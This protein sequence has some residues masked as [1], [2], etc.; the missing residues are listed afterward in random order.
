MIPRFQ[1]LLKRGADEALEFWSVPFFHI[2]GAGMHYPR[3]DQQGNPI[4]PPNM[5]PAVKAFGPIPFY[6]AE[7]P[8]E[9]K[10]VDDLLAA[11]GFDG[12]WFDSNDVEGFLREKG[13]FLDGH[14]SF[15]E[16]SQEHVSSLQSD[17]ERSPTMITSNG[18]QATRGSARISI[19]HDSPAAVAEQQTASTVPR[20]DTGGSIRKSS[21]QR[22]SL[23]MDVARFLEC[24]YADISVTIPQ[25]LLLL[26]LRH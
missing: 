23:V 16:L 22:S 26:E 19:S 21:H 5:H 1:K 6:L 4:Y 10:S 8:H 11:I 25:L 14:S 13:I 24:E 9:K 20:T 3:K 17:G 7:T 18:S 12:E 2:G 15:V